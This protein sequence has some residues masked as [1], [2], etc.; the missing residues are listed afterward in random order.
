[1][2]EKKEKNKEKKMTFWQHLE[3]LRWV[4]IYSFISI[5]IGSTVSFIFKNFVFNSIILAPK[6]PDFITNDLLCRLSDIL[7]IKSICINSHPLE[8][9]NIDLAGQFYIHIFISITT[10]V[11]IS[12]PIILWLLW[13]FIKP[14]LLEKEK[15]H[16]KGTVL[17]TSILF[18]IGIAFSYFIIVPLTINFL[19][20]YQVSEFINNRISL[21]SYVHTI[22]SLSFA[23]GIVF[24]LPAIVYFLTKTGIINSIMMKKN[25]KIVFVILLIISAI[26]T[27]PDVFSQLLVC[28][29][30]VLLYELSINISKRI[31]KKNNLLQG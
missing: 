19:G 6:N 25:R 27:P 26:I 23:V 20:N 17:I 31:E 2:P 15:K 21:S 5:L 14:A 28:F 12:A 9:I 1:M 22:V 29:P 7:S 4:I 13:R 24:E 10:G 30:L 3:E 18:Y 11:I 16:T 8:I